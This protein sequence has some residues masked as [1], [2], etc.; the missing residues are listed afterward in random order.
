METK[1]YL[2][3]LKTCSRTSACDPYDLYGDQALEIRPQWQFKFFK[4]AVPMFSILLNPCDDRNLLCKLV[5]TRQSAASGFCSD[6]KSALTDMFRGFWDKNRN[7][8]NRKGFQPGNS[9]MSAQCINH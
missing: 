8:D 1:P 3:S 9:G 5:S 7:R 4:M 6:R 2:D